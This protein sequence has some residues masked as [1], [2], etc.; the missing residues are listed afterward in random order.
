MT[1]Q[2]S[3]SKPSMSPALDAVFQPA[4]LGALTVANRLVFAATSSELAD[5]VGAVTDEMIEYYRVRAAGGVGLIVVEAT[6]VSHEGKR[7]SHNA[8]IDHDDCIPGLARLAAAIKAHGTIAIIQLNHGGRESVSGVSGRVVAPSAIP[9]GYTAVGSADLPHELTAEE[10]DE[11]IGQFVDAA[12]RAKRAGFD[13][14]EFH[15]AHGYLISE[16]LSPNANH[17]TDAW[18][19]SLEGRANFYLEIVRRT[20]AV[21]GEGFAIV[22]RINARDGDA[23][24]D[25]LEIDESILVSQWLE[26]AGADSISVTAGLHASRPYLPIAGMSQPRGLFLPFGERFRAA[27]G[28]PV[29]IVGRLKTEASVLAAADVADFIC[30]SRA[31]IADPG[32][33]RKLRDGRSA[34]V[35]PCIACNECLTSVHRHRGIVCTMNPAASREREFAAAEATP[36]VRQRVVVVGGGV[37]G[38]ACAGTAAR[39]GHDVTLFERSGRL[40]GQLNLA[41]VPPHRDELR[42]ALD[43][44]IREVHRWGVDVRLEADPTEEAISALR[45]DHVIVAIGASPRDTGIPGEHLA[46]VVRGQEVL[47]GEVAPVGKV[48]VVGGGLVGIEVAD[49]LAERDHEVVL[50]ARSG[51]LKKAVHADRVY[52]LD[53]IAALGIDV[54]LDTGVERI[55][56]DRVVLTDSGGE[57]SIINDVGVVALCVGYDAQP[58]FAA[59]YATSGAVLTTIGDATAS[60]KLFEA[61]EEGTLTAI[62]L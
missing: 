3:M 35:V 61:I 62:R 26:R 32:F 7:L 31:L 20:R 40:G 43:H 15:G 27:L 17:R 18:G 56:G 47:S 45:P 19:G 2:A 12:V 36:A 30:L 29:M 23:I 59:R 28:I 11:V 25:G 14:V 41:H 1:I 51:I 48:V 50:V 57:P 55:E 24:V 53:R 38:L 16:F 42:T 60:R 5:D 10:I 6:Y 8:M 39:R 34:D 22:C 4:M 52:F 49:Y 37:A 54:W 33:P 13:G 44:L 46:T 21:V 58:D 9:S